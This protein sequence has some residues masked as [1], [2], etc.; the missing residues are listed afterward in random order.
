MNFD[1]RDSVPIFGYEGYSVHLAWN[2]TVSNI[3]QNQNLPEHKYVAHTQQITQ[4]FKYTPFDG[5]H[6]HRGLEKKILVQFAL[7]VSRNYD[8][9]CVNLLTS[10]HKRSPTWT[11][12]V[13]ASPIV[14]SFV[15]S[16]SFSTVKKQAGPPVIPPCEATDQRKKNSRTI[17]ELRVCMALI[18]CTQYADDEIYATFTVHIP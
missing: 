4:D 8:H 7:F 17:C 15:F 10:L 18:I 13:V 16:V 12:T 1:G 3:S 2:T 11:S 6:K 9:S 14:R 5:T